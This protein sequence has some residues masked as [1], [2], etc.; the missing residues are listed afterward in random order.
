MRM[1]KMTWTD[2]GCLNIAYNFIL[3]F[4]NCNIIVFISFFKNTKTN[5]RI[6]KLFEIQL[7]CC[8]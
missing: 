1:G 8:F 3:N 7:K 6:Q 4:L 5:F 2:F